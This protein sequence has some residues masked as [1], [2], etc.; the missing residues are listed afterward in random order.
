VATASFTV[1]ASQQ[2]ADATRIVTDRASYNAAQSVQLSSRAAN[3]TSNGVQEDL[4]AVTVV[5]NAAGQEVFAQIEAIGQLAP[6]AQRQYSYGLAASGLA[7]GNHLASLQLL[8]AQ[9]AVLS[10]SSTSFNVLGADQSGV[11][12]TGQLQAMPSVVLIGQPVALSLAATN[13]GNT[14]LSNVPISLRL[15]EPTSGVIVASFTNTVSAWA[16]GSSQSLAWSWTA[17]GLDGQTLVAAASVN[18]AGR[19]IA[20]GQAN[21]R[22]VGVPLLKAEPGQ[23]DFPMVF[24][25]ET[26]AGLSATISSIGSAT[27]TS[28][29]LSL[30]GA[31]PSQFVLPEGGCAQ[32][33]SL[34]IGGTCT[35]TVSYRPSEAGNHSA[36]LRIAYATGGDVIVKLTGQATPIVLAGSVAPAPAEIHLG[37]ATS[38]AW[39]LS[40]PA[41]ANL[42]AAISLSL[43]DGAGQGVA[44]WPIVATLGP[45]ASLAGNQIHTA[46][47]VAQT[48][49][50]VLRQDVAG[51]STVLATTSLVVTEVPVKLGGPAQLKGEARILVLASCPAA[52]SNLDLDDPNPA[53][54]LAEEG[55]AQGDIAACAQQRAGAVGAYLDRLGIFNKVVTT[56][57]EFQEEMRCGIYNTYWISGGAAKLD[58][59]LVRE[60]R[61]AV[62]KG[63]GLIMDGE[64]DA[65]NHL[66]HPVAGVKYQGKLPYTNI[67]ASIGAGSIY[68]GGPLATLGQPSKF[69]VLT[70][71]SQG[72]FTQVPGDQG[73]APAIVSNRYGNGSTLLFAFNL[74]A[75][76]TADPNAQD[77][78]LR[79]VVVASANQVGSV[80]DVLTAAD[81]A[82]LSL[83]LNNEGN[84]AAI[85]QVVASLPAGLSYS[86]SNV[87]PG[88]QAG[89]TVTWTISMPAQAS[90]ELVVRVRADQSGEY[91]I[92][93]AL[94]SLN[95][96]G[97]VTS[98]LETANLALSV[99]PA[100]GRLQAPTSV[101]QAIAA[102]TSS[103][104]AAKNKAAKAVADAQAAQAEGQYQQALG[105]WVS[106]TDALISIAGA[107]S[108]AARNAISL[109]IESSQDALC[110]VMACIGGTM[111][112]NGGVPLGDSLRVSTTVSNNCSA[113]VAGLTLAGVITNRR[114]GVAMSTTQL[115]ADVAAAHPQGGQLSWQPQE[116]QVEAGDW[117]DSVVTA[118]WQ[119]Q[120]RRLGQASIQVGAQSS[121]CHDGWTAPPER[122]TAFAGDGLQV[123]GGKSGNVDW[124]WALGTDASY[125]TA[126]VS[127]Q[128]GKSYGWQLGINSAGEGNFSVYDGTILV[129][130]SSYSNSASKLHLGQAI[131]LGLSSA[132]DVGTA[133]ISA[134]IA[135]LNGQMTQVSLATDAPGQD[136]AAVLYHSSL[137]SGITVQGTVRLDFTGTAPP[138]G[139]KLLMTVQPGN[140]SCQ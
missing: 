15:I 43:I 47:G 128:S 26:A 41:T 51:T 36:D 56:A 138:Q 96:S 76:L 3:L 13:S 44:T 105:H 75:M 94:Y 113:P 110:Q 21:I 107:D 89:S 7:V 101:V 31:N 49:T 121:A 119:G 106:A 33:A 53:L 114:T 140:A 81:A 116:G 4:R 115:T 61:E 24:A 126:H 93:I 111:T 78:R 109:A 59:L 27:A 131:R 112:A 132:S 28:V 54:A 92:P 85:V 86:G 63:E 37:E 95:G 10:Q 104:L 40:N 64:H 108:T 100:A 71:Q 46:A 12:V 98:A 83:T 72:L 2:Q 118:Q 62:W 45:N 139:S 134:A 82:A 103:E 32:T 99:A 120:P 77:A 66:L 137:A 30:S 87:S 17:Q 73:P 133:R 65:R 130:Q 5:R 18:V 22:M 57:T 23:L 6:G 91:V 34:P 50:A 88:T 55:A 48:L 80:A 42:T 70:G 38:L 19:D 67:A 68:A 14:A 16:Q 20:L 117:L 129:A 1:T 122:F 52:E 90:Q 29:T 9:G 60:L 39:S 58:R 11:G 124:E 8:N 102:N 127:W 123:K 25:G 69:E 97:Q 74:A 136:K 79:H 125:S 35:L 84:A 135:S